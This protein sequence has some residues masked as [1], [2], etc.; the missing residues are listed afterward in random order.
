M[1]WHPGCGVVLSTHSITNPQNKMPTEDWLPPSHRAMPSW[2]M[3]GDWVGN[4]SRTISP[5]TP[6]PPSLAYA[7][8]ESRCQL[9]TS[10]VDNEGGTSVR[11]RSDSMP[12]PATGNS[13]SRRELSSGYTDTTGTSNAASAGFSAEEPRWVAR[14]AHKSKP[15]R[16]EDTRNEEQAPTGK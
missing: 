11:A 4:P 8:Q 16:F 5:R 3:H 13:S 9:V 14:T 6:S 1:T 12:Q 10:I 2:P 7:L 15:N